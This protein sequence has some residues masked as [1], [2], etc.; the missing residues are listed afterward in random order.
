[1]VAF[2][3]IDFDKVDDEK[4]FELEDIYKA[5]G[6]VPRLK[7]LIYMR[8]CYIDNCS[9]DNCECTV[10]RLAQITGLSQSATSHQLRDLRSKKIIK[11]RKV[12]LNVIYSL[13][14]EHIFKIIQSGL[15]HVVE[16]KPK[17]KDSIE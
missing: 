17:L 2:E 6:S 14:D 13:H 8:N 4:L 7:M 16:S 5:F 9:V 11:G 15:E 12:G 1:M 3:D 10:T